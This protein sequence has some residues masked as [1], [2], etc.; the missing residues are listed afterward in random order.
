MSY[1]FAKDAGVSSSL[2]AL[3][4]RGEGEGSVNCKDTCG[5]KNVTQQ[6]QI[7]FMLLEDQNIL[8]GEE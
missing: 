7:M 4:N 8:R 3:K 1:R 2:T 6:L 5:A